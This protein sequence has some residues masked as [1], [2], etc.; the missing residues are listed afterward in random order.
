MAIDLS[1]SIEKSFLEIQV[2]GIAIKFKRGMYDRTSDGVLISRR[3]C[4]ITEFSS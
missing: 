2:L 1:V 3:L 4:I